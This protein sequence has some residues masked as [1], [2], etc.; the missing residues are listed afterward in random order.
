MSNNTEETIRRRNPQLTEGQVE[1]QAGLQDESP[2]YCN[3]IHGYLTSNNGIEIIRTKHT[4]IKE[5]S[6]FI[7]FRYCPKCGNK[8]S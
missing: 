4:P 7:R 5:N 8:L 1:R 6:W 3:H 2:P